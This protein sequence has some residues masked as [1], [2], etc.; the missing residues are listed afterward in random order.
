MSMSSYLSVPLDISKEERSQKV[1]H[2]ARGIH[3]SRYHF[4]DREVKL[5]VINLIKLMYEMCFDR[6]VSGHTIAK[7][8]SNVAPRI[9]TY[10][11]GSRARV[12]FFGGG[13]HG[14]S[15]AQT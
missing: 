12:F 11:G 4:L 13:A 3:T 7:I 14:E 10:T 2:F 9:V 6:K 5:K 1:L 15:G 8:N